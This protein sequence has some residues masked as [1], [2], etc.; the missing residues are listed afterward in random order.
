MGMLHQLFDL[1]HVGKTV[2]FP[3]VESYE[4]V[5]VR[6]SLKQRGNGLVDDK[7]DSGM[8]KTKPKAVA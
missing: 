5:N 4:A 3:F 7:V 6:M 8:W 1:L 2:A